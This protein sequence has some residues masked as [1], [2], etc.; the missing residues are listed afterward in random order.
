MTTLSA[1]YAREVLMCEQPMTIGCGRLDLDQLR[2][3]ADQGRPLYSFNV[4]DFYALHTAFLTAGESHAGII[5]AQQRSSIGDQL[6]GVLKLIAAK[7]A[8]DML[9]QIV[10]LSAWTS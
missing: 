2:W 3:A 4:G 9:N 5:V 7:S 10:F 8:E 1:R 6:R